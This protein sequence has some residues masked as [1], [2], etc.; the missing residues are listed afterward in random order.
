MTFRIDGSEIG[1]VIEIATIVGSIV[2]VLIVALF[3]YLLVRPPRRRPP[4]RPELEAA[5]AEEM[6]AVMERM[7][8]RLDALE[9]AVGTETRDGEKSLG[10]RER[11]E[12]RRVK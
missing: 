11:P 5:E 2:A 9:R 4:A 6:L 1:E 10:A 3:I 8:R 7:E 12:L